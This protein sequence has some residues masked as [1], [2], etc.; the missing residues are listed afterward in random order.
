MLTF[1]PAATEPVSLPWTQ[2]RQIEV[3]SKRVALLS[4]LEPTAFQHTPYLNVPWPLRRDRSA[5][6]G[7]IRLGRIGYAKGLGMHSHSEVSFALKP[8]CKQFAAIIGIDDAVRPRGS[9]VFRVRADGKEVFASGPVSGRDKPRPVLVNIA[10][11][12]TLTLVVEF[13]PEADLSDHADWALAR[14]VR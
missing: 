7:P 11:A 1:A 2:V 6:N 14:V 5:S 13:G 4:D 8:G 3:R 10:G 12:T 9:V